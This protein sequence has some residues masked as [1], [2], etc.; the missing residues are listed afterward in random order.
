VTRHNKSRKVKGKHG[1]ARKG[2]GRKPKGT[3]TNKSAW[4]STR[5][6]DDT[7]EK[8]ELAANE[9]DRSLSQ[10]IEL[11]LRGSFIERERDPWLR[12]LAYLIGEVVRVSDIKGEDLKHEPA[13]YVMFKAAVVAILDALAPRGSID[14]DDNELGRQLGIVT[15]N[16]ILIMLQHTKTPPMGWDSPI[17]EWEY[18]MP[19]A[20]EALLSPDAPLLRMTERLRRAFSQQALHDTGTPF[21]IDKNDGGKDEPDEGPVATE[22][23]SSDGG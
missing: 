22:P 2:A 21:S 16:T 12:A 13:L 10:E 19:Q 17:D 11:R 1:G 3:L 14:H 20:R 15:A 5:I 7:R 6:R 4:L 9:N 23:S 8:L 18:A